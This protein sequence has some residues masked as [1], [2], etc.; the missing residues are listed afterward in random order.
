M[1]SVDFAAAQ[2]RVVE[3]RRLRAAEKKARFQSQ[4]NLHASNALNRLPFPLDGLGQRGLQAWEA[5]KG[6][7]GTRPAYRVGQIDAELLDEELLELLKSQF[8]EGLKFFG[9]YFIVPAAMSI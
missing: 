3:R 5:I 6:R 9:V 2:K 1:T 4:R 7:E 8:G